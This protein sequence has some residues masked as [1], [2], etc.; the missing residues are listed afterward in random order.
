MTTKLKVSILA[1]AALLSLGGAGVLQ[2]QQNNMSFFVTSA[3]SGKGGDLG[4]IAGAD[5]ICQQLATDAGA[6]GKTWRAYVSSNTGRRRPGRQ[7]PRPHR[8]RSVAECQGRRHRQGR[9]TICRPIRTSTRKPC[10]TRRATGSRCAVIT[11]T[12]TTCDRLDLQGR[13]F[14][15]NLNLTC[16]NWTSSNFG[17]GHARP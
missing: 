7:R 17:I 11:R 8:Q 9:R 10:S 5:A 12:S 4:G 16:N 3:G 6:G 15:G 14:P 1:S 2:A 13:A